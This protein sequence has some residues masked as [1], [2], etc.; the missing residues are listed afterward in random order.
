MR[1]AASYARSGHA[2]RIRVV[3]YTDASG[4]VSYNEALSKQRAT[5][6]ANALT[7]LGVTPTIMDVTWQGKRNLAVPT[8]DGVR[9]PLNRRSTIDVE[10]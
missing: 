10:F 1:D 3:G 9:E 2:T 7:K 5:V 8:P 4:S 6:M